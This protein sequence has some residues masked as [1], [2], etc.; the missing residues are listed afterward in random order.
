M[1][2]SENLGLAVVDGLVNGS[3]IAFIALGLA[4]VFGIMNVVNLTHGEL[5]MF[6]A[7]IS[8]L[9]VQAALPYASAL[10]VAPLL[11]GGLAVVINMLILQRFEHEPGQTVLA[12]F[13]LLLIMQQVGLAVLGPA[14]RSIPPPFNPIIEFSGFSYS[15]FKLLAG[16]ISLAAS[17][18][19]WI[20]VERSR[21]GPLLR[22]AQENRLMAES[23]GIN[24]SRVFM[25]GFVL[26]GSLVGLAGALT[27][28]FRQIHFL[29]GFD[30]LA[31]SFVVVVLGGVGRIGGT[32]AAGVALGLLESLAALFLA[33]TVARVLTL[34]LALI[35]IVARRLG[36]VKGVWRY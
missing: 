5:Y 2:P 24:T 3:V 8:W 33:P 23:L 15:G 6:G 7:M 11:V 28:P 25:I 14:P 31:M 4:I 30:A 10:V 26:A 35:Y 36:S 32:I 18:L 12:T 9:L 29:M 21:I 34:T 1:F 22:A 20:G 16:M 17:L 19:V 13:G 27:S